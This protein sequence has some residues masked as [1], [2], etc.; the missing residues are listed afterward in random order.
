MTI[1]SAKGLEFPVVFLPGL[2]EGIFPGMAS[3]SS[4]KELEEERRLAYVAVTRAKEKLYL[5]HARERMLFG[6]TQYNQLSRFVKEYPHKITIL[7]IK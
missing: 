2:E 5:T 4:P 7:C 1:H 3:M 6:H